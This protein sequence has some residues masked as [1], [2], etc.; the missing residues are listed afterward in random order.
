[1]DYSWRRTIAERLGPSFRETMHGS[2]QAQVEVDKRKAVGMR[3]GGVESMT[4]GL[5]APQQIR[6]E[7]WRTGAVECGLLQRNLPDIVNKQS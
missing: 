1:M 2:R 3:F 5:D 6:T 7:V 4:L